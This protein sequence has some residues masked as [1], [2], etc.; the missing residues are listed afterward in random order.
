[1]RSVEPIEIGSNSSVLQISGLVLNDGEGGGRASEEVNQPVREWDNRLFGVVDPSVYINDRGGGGADISIG[2]ACDLEVVHL[3]DPFGRSI[4]ALRSEDLEVRVVAVVLDIARRGSGEGVF[5]MQDLLLQAGEGVVEGVDRLLVLFLSLF[6]GLS[7]TLNDVGE[8]GNG[9]FSRIAVEKIQG[10]PWGEWRAL[11]VW[12]IEHADWI[13]DWRIQC[14]TLRRYDGLER[15]EDRLSSVIGRRLWRGVGGSNPKLNGE[16]RSGFGGNERGNRTSGSRR[17]GGFDRGV[18]GVVRHRAMVEELSD[19]CEE[20]VVV[21]I[22]SR[23]CFR[24]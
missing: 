4:D 6:D 5:V 20:T 22:P 11:V 15:G 17:H 23:G 2:E 13:K 7:E 16:R 9:E 10:G 8:E 3:L 18:D 24:W 14:G 1:M 21:F 19:D 12:V